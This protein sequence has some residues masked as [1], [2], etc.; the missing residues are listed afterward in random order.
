M[1]HLT[2]IRMP[3]AQFELYVDASLSGLGLAHV[4]N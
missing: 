4:S 2:S 3:D 1:E